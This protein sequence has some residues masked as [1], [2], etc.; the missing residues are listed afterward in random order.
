MAVR[1]RHKGDH[2]CRLVA[3][4]A[5][6]FSLVTPARV[7]VRVRTARPPPIAATRRIEQRLPR[8]Q[9]ARLQP[10]RRV[11]QDPP[12]TRQEKKDPTPAPCRTPPQPRR[13]TQTTRTATT[14]KTTI[15]APTPPHHPPRLLHPPD[16][17]PFTHPHTHLVPELTA[18]NNNRTKTRRTDGGRP[19]MSY[20][21]RTTRPRDI[22]LVDPLYTTPT[23]HISTEQLIHVR[24]L[25]SCMH[26]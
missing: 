3:H 11:S 22:V 4:D 17:P 12:G 21:Y 24:S 7:S 20:L 16:L 26:L 6:P 23:P 2:A 19:G 25:I 9:L 13:L 18:L 5:L 1:Q 8:K 14:T 15:H 10:I